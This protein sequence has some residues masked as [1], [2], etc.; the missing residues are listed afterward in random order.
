MKKLLKALFTVAALI[1]SV[2]AV[3]YMIDYFYQTYSDR[4]ITSDIDIDA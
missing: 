2:K 4:Y 1:L 3:L